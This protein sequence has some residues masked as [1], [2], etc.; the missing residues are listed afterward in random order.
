V[1]EVLRW[2]A[3][4]D[5]TASRAA[6]DPWREVYNAQR[7]HEAIGMD[8]PAK[9]Y[10]P[11]P[12]TYPSVLP[13]VVYPASDLTRKVS[14]NS[15]IILHGK[16]YGIGKAFRGQTIALRPTAVDGVWDVFYCRHRVGGPDERTG[17]PMSRGTADP[18]AAFAQPTAE[19]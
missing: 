8:V 18:L 19:T 5:L 13:E 7:P 9:R 17:A 16:R 6:F 12:R 1:A 10:A 15:G 4:D 3:F 2:Q 14:G 11:S